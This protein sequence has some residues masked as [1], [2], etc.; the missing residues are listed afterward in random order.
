MELHSLWDKHCR[1]LLTRT[2]NLL[3][4][5]HSGSA[6]PIHRVTFRSRTFTGNCDRASDNHFLRHRQRLRLH[7][8]TL[9]LFFAVAPRAARAEGDTPVTAIANPQATSSGSVSNNAVQVLQGPFFTNSYGG[10]VSCQGPTLNFTPF[11]FGTASGQTPFQ[12]HAN[13]DNDPSTPL[14]R[15]GQKDNWSLNPGLSLTLSFPLDGGLQARCKAAAEAW[16]RRQQAETDKSRL[17]FELVRL[18]RCGEALKAGVMFHPQSPYA[19]VCSDVIVVRPDGT[20]SNVPLSA[21][22]SNASQSSSPSRP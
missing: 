12:S 10:G 3:S 16:I 2:W 1:S 9:A 6:V 11:V 15:T 7:A 17:D 8:I 18:L 19:R 22:A 14:E 5:S 4:C 21:P 13:L 20:A